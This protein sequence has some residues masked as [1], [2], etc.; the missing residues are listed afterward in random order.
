MLEYSVVKNADKKGKRE[1]EKKSKRNPLSALIEG[2][3]SL[4][5]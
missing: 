3:T 4:W 2:P 1:K 5:L